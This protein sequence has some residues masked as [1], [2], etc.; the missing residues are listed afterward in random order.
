MGSSIY[1]MGYQTAW[2]RSALGGGAMVELDTLSQAL[3]EVRGRALHRLAEEARHVGADAVV[4]VETRAGES[5]LGGAAGSSRSS[6][7]CS[8][9]PCAARAPAASSR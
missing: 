6:T 2:G 5:D 8:A 7:W 1:Q 3:N 9:P 4:G